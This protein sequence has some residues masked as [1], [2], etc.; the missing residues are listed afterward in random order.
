M[1]DYSL[2]G[3]FFLSIPV[4][5]ARPFIG[6]LIWSWFNYMNPHR[7]TY[8]IAYSFDF[9]MIA[10]IATLIGVVFSK[11]PKKLNLDGL[12]FAWIAFV[13][14]MSFTTIFAFNEQGAMFEW[15]RMMK[16]QILIL[17]TLLFVTSKKRVNI[18]VWVIALSIGFYGIKGGFFTIITGGTFR[19][20][21][22]IGSFIEGNN[23]LALALIM[24]LP[25]MRYLH[26]IQENNKIKLAL[27]CSM[28]LVV[29]AIVASYSRGA[30]LAAGTMLLFIWLKSSKKVLTGGILIVAVMAILAFM[31]S[32][33]FD[34]MST[35]EEYQEDRSAMGRINAWNFA[36]NLAL[37]R[38]IVGGGFNAFIPDLFLVY[39]PVPT[40]YH[41]AHSIY[42]EVLGEHG[43]V[44]L[45]IFLLMGFLVLYTGNWIKVKTKDNKE[46]FWAKNLAEMLQVSFIGYAV[47][48][49]FL[50]L[51]YY[52]LPYHIMSIMIIIHHLVKKK[53]ANMIVS[54]DNYY[55]R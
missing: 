23:E 20:W 52:D 38:P 31:P 35:I 51:A 4:M 44:G 54:N 6:I 55:Y 46:L 26:I 22:P 41:D 43:F 39:A 2:L 9:V 33:W 7:L 37:D 10:A 32:E 45:F 27:L 30:F 50:G 49:A 14:W 13:A 18:L 48:G 36:Y 40:D 53:L 3:F 29:I 34:R 24:I 25:L 28:G 8:G 47:G 21:G 11:E 17:L 19:V 12:A 15:T 5:V 42:F 1:R 16:T